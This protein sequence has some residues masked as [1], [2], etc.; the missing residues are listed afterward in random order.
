[1]GKK[2]SDGGAHREDGVKKSEEREKLAMIKK[3]SRP[4]KDKKMSF[5]ESFY[6]DFNPNNPK[7]GFKR[8]RIME[9]GVVGEMVSGFVL[10]MSELLNRWPSVANRIVNTEHKSRVHEDIYININDV[11]AEPDKRDTERNVGWSP[12]VVGDMKENFFLRVVRVS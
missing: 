4:K 2:V 5:E 12:E 8:M 1:M 9:N 11:P 6:Q 10:S 7:A 3:A